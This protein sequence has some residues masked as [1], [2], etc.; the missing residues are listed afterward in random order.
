[1][2]YFVSIVMVVLT[3]TREVMMK[4]LFLF[5]FTLL[6]LSFYQSSFT[7]DFLQPSFK[8][9]ITYSYPANEY[10]N[11]PQVQENM[12][13]KNP[14]TTTRVIQ[15]NGQY[16]VLP[17]NVRPFP[18]TVTQS[19]VDAANMKGNDQVIYAAW[20]SYGPSFLGAGFCYSSDGRYKLV[21]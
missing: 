18:S 4:N 12:N 5:I 7:Q 14:N 17:P 20:N 21:R 3:K 11:L 1:M 9:P 19:E 6:I 2:F 13:Y 15:K 16:F 8:I 10:S